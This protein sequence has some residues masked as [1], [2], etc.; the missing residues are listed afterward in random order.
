[1][2]EASATGGYKLI[3]EDL[4]RRLKHA[5]IITSAQHLDL[6]LNDAGEVEAPFF[7]RTYLLS[8]EGVRRSD[9]QRFSDATGSALIYYILKG[10]RCRPAGKFVT[11]AELAGP[12]FKQGS[13]STSALER[14]IIKRF[15]GRV[16]ELLAAAA[17]VGGRQGGEAGLGS[18]SLIFNLF[19]HIPMQLI[20]YDSD[21]E[22]PARATLLFDLNAT[23]LV[24]F[25][26]LAVVVTLFVQS[27]AKL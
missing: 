1:M 7:G 22:F 24:D 2:K 10:S 8:S 17:S 15:Q 9:G 23:Q 25:E 6:E 3:Y 16:S 5:D 19:P 14:P 4:L 11:L 12:L 27:L 26:V 20:F 13:Y 18:V 21:D